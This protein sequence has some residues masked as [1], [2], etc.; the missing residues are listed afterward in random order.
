MNNL[1]K[2]ERKKK[3]NAASTHIRSYAH[4]IAGGLPLCAGEALPL[5]ARR[6]PINP[7]QNTKREKACGTSGP[8]I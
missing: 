8:T 5:R 4:L 1:L 2:E 3:G 6:A 7:T